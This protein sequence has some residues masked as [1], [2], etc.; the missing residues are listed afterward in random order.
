MSTFVKQAGCI[1]INEFDQDMNIDCLT[2][3][4]VIN[5][6]IIPNLSF[7]SVGTTNFFESVRTIDISYQNIN[8][9]SQVDTHINILRK[10]FKNMKDINLLYSESLDIDTISKILGNHRINKLL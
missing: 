9:E 8:K 10:Y 1:C 6:T 2:E 4:I 7:Y 3:K 5:S